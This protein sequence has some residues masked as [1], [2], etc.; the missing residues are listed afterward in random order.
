MNGD[1]FEQNAS[2]YLGEDASALPAVGTFLHWVNV[3][4]PG[5]KPDLFTMYGWVSA[6]LF[7]QGLKKAGSDPSRGSLLQALSKIT[8]FNGDNLIA[9]TDPAA[10][11]DGN[12]YDRPSTRTGCAADGRPADLG[13]QRLATVATART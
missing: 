9:T 1:D 13:G 8:S 3:A 11:T 12:C 7:A 6:Q 10:K 4:S 2:L 5:S